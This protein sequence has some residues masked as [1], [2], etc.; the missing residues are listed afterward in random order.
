MDSYDPQYMIK[1]DLYY[2]IIIKPNISN[3]YFNPQYYA[4]QL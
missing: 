3:S 2:E 4:N 1:P